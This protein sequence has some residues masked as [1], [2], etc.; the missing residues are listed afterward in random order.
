MT[1]PQTADPASPGSSRPAR[2]RH[3][4]FPARL[5]WQ[6]DL[7]F[8]RRLI[9]PEKRCCFWHLLPSRPPLRTN[10][11]MKPQLPSLNNNKKPSLRFA[12]RLKC[13]NFSWKDAW[14]WC[15]EIVSMGMD[16]LHFIQSLILQE[17]LRPL[18]TWLWW[19][20]SQVEERN[21]TSW[22][23]VSNCHITFTAFKW[24]KQVMSCP[25]FKG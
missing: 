19:Q 8:L 12:P 18:F 2:L 5:I 25:I 23:L 6:C 24:S 7:P 10:S 3:T 21:E 16:H 1:S 4:A 14:G 17:P 9:F 20:V 22:S 13:C 15:T 11:E